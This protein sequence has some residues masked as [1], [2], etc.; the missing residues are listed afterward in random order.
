MVTDDVAMRCR[1]VSYDL[2][3]WAYH[4]FGYFWPVLCLNIT[5]LWLLLFLSRLWFDFPRQAADTQHM[6]RT[7]FGYSQQLRHKMWDGCFR[8]VPLQGLSESL[9]LLCLT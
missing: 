6:F 3:V 4:G 1:I 9:G 7:L 8:L 2:I 5:R